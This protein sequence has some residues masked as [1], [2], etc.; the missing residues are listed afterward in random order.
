MW[1]K[2]K[3][4]KASDDN[5]EDENKTTMKQL[6]LLLGSSGLNNSISINFNHI[7]F[8]ND[9]TSDTAFELNKELRKVQ[10]TIKTI[11]ASLNIEP[12]PIYLHLTTD[13]GLIYSAF[14][15]IDC[16]KSLSVPVHTI[17]DGFVASAGTLIS[18]AGEKRHNHYVR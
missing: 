15:V 4:R 2:N 5:E 1:G 8:N 16:I 11:S 13:G 9:I 17:I 12:E 10:I 14:S 18:L 6:S 3:K 7:Y